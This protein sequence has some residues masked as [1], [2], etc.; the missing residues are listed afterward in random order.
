MPAAPQDRYNGTYNTVVKDI[1]FNTNGYLEGFIVN[2]NKR[3]EMKDLFYYLVNNC[4]SYFADKESGITVS[5]VFSK[6]SKGKAESITGI[7]ITGLYTFLADKGLLEEDISKE[8]SRLE[9]I[10]E[11]GSLSPE[12]VAKLSERISEVEMLIA[13]QNGYGN[14]L[15]WVRENMSIDSSIGFGKFAESLTKK[16]LI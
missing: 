15:K 12:E 11:A 7:E 10:R 13:M 8:L 2:D 3:I 6:D 14:R 5:L 9:N 1:Y 16:G 4:F